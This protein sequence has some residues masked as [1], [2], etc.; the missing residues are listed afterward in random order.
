MEINALREQL[1]QLQ[2]SNRTLLQDIMQ[3][4]RGGKGFGYGRGNGQ[5]ARWQMRGTAPWCPYA[6]TQ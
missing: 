1:H 6:N 3:G 4:S 2:I 5:G